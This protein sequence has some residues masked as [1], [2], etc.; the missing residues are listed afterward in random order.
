MIIFCS[1]VA[2]DE[3]RNLYPNA[4]DLIDNL[5]ASSQ[6]GCFKPEAHLL[7]EKFLSLKKE[8]S[9][10]FYISNMMN[11]T[12]IRHLVSSISKLGGTLKHFLVNAQ[13]FL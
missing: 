13:L 4:S 7:I 12:R 6:E 2:K 8:N 11:H 10:D 9:R 3:L 5:P 1:L